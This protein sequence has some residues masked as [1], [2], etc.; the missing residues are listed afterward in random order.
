MV[1]TTGSSTPTDRCLAR[2][3]EHKKFSKTLE[4]LKTAFVLSSEENLKALRSMGAKKKKK[5][6]EKSK[7]SLKKV[8]DKKSKNAKGRE[9]KD[10]EEPQRKKLKK[11]KLSEGAM[12]FVEESATSD[13]AESDD[14]V[15]SGKN[16]KVKSKQKLNSPDGDAKNSGD[17]GEV[18]EEAEEEEKVQKSGAKKGLDKR[19]KPPAFKKG[20]PNAPKQA[21]KKENQRKT[22]AAEEAAIH[23]Q[24]QERTE[25]SFFVTSTGQSYMAA[26]PKSAPAEARPRDVPSQESWAATNPKRDF[27]SNNFTNG[28]ERS[29]VQRGSFN[30]EN[31]FRSTRTPEAAA[32]AADDNLHP[33]WKAK[34]RLKEIK[35]FQGKKIVFGEEGEQVQVKTPKVVV[36]EKKTTQPSQDPDLH[37]SWL[38]KQKAKPTIAEF[39]GKKIKFD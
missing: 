4:G 38:A 15:K 1:L 13:E 9:P 28:R 16:A 19:Q 25:D 3:W 36:Q 39:T 21:K 10:D 34:Q 30:S 33:S 31:S 37:P 7:K 8:K 14:E 32:A 35:P 5:E 23:T 12:D 29:N 6:G 24:L 11:A 22:R 2:L 18:S 26:V 20:A 27:S 17:S